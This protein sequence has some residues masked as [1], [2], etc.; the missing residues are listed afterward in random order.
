MTIKEEI[1]GPQERSESCAGGK[2][3]EVNMEVVAEPY[4]DHFNMTTSR[5]MVIV[6]QCANRVAN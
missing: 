3:Q 5:C 2:E 6:V 4:L 1:V